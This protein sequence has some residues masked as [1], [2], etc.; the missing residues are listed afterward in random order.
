MAKQIKKAAKT[1]NAV[2]VAKE[3]EITLHDAVIHLQNSIDVIVKDNLKRDQQIA[4]ISKKLKDLK[5]KKDKKKK[6]KTAKK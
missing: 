4:E 2:K 1:T 5:A 6:N 3:K